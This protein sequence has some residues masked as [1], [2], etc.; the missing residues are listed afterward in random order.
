MQLIRSI[1]GSG[2][3]LALALLSGCAVDEQAEAANKKLIRDYMEIVF[4]QGAIE[5]LPEFVSSDYV[6]VSGGDSYR[7]GLEGAKAHAEGV[8]AAFPDIR[9]TIDQQ[10]CEGNWVVSRITASGTHTGAWLGMMPTG[11]KLTFTG[12]NINRV[13]DGL[14]QEH[15][16]AA[17]LFGPLLEAGVIQL[18]S[19]I[20]GG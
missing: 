11:K 18:S 3:L 7:L 9:I 14:I 16:G 15:G 17:N 5:R 20:E 19:G 8:R 6:E 2:L 10:V 13:E 12:V 1:S 4:N